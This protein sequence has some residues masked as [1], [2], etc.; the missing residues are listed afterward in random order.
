MYG[1]PLRPEG[2]DR[3]IGMLYA[4]GALG[5]VGAGLTAGAE[6]VQLVHRQAALLCRDPDE[7]RHS[8]RHKGQPILQIPAK[9]HH[10]HCLSWSFGG[11]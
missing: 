5:E 10:C 8:L 2:G 6:A 9:A 7:L 4:E 3:E 11:R 1:E